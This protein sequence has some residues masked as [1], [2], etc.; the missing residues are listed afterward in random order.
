MSDAATGQ[1]VLTGTAP[2]LVL[3]PGANTI[4][5]G[6]V[7]PVAY[8]AGVGYTIDGNANGF[9]PVGVFNI[10]YVLTRWNNDISDEL[11]EECITAEVE[12]ISP[13]QLL[14]PGDS[15]RVLTKRPFFT[16][17]PPAPVTVFTNL[18]YNMTLVEVQ[19]MQSGLDAIQQNSP[20]LNPSNIAFTSLQYPL[21]MPELDTGKTYAWRVT[22]NNNGS[23]VANSEVWSFRV[24][25]PDHYTSNAAAS[26]GSYAALK[27]VIDAS[28]IIT[29]HSLRFYYTHELAD[30][31]VQYNITAISTSSRRPLTTEDSLL[32]VVYG[33]N[34]I[35]LSLDDVSGITDKHM[36]LLELISSKKEHY[37][38]RFEYRK[39]NAQ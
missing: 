39:S 15:D 7:A 32:H 19:P 20:L 2:A 11:A 8:T 35:T 9:L 6:R 31:T 33:T 37:Y 12:P 30:S 34:Y 26:N 38:L 1:T 4:T 18:T 21:S 22:A 23:P 36:Y 14:Q 27:R 25:L 10:C 28:Y 13:P 5:P 24:P 29:N 16:W 17:L 3:Q